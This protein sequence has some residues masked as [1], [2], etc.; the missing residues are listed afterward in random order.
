MKFLLTTLVLVGWSST[1]SAQAVCEPGETRA[2]VVIEA[3]SGLLCGGPLGSWEEVIRV[4]V[5][6]VLS[7]P[8]VGPVVA[9]VV[10]CPGRNILVGRVVEMCLG[11]T[12]LP[13]AETRV[14]TLHNDQSPRLRA[15]ALRTVRSRR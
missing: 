4:R 9:A 11:G 2:E 15:R 14:D 1:A 6:R 13:T 10:W 8:Q 5:R 3:A 12:A 7:G